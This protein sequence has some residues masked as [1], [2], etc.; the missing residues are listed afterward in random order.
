M[1]FSFNPNSSFAFTPSGRSRGGSDE[2]NIFEGA[3]TGGR[4][5]RGAVRLETPSASE[6][7]SPISST[8]EGELFVGGEA[9]NCRQ[10]D[11]EPKE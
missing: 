6:E 9:R 11:A 10:S 4:H 1:G 7:S 2:L 8:D 5:E 3:D